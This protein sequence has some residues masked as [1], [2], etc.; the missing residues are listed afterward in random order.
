VLVNTPKE[1]ARIVRCPGCGGNSFYATSNPYRP[2]CSARCKNS[3]FGAWASEG[4]RLASGTE[5]ND[6]D[7]SGES[8]D[9]AP[10]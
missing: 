6:G 3:D 1:P 10:H 8:G 4:Y 5:S 2:F 7:E 9:P